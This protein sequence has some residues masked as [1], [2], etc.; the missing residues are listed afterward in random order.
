[1][2]FISRS[3][4]QGREREAATKAKEE[5][6]SVTPREVRDPQFLNACFMSLIKAEYKNE[7]P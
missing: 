3:G 6:D 2:G 5:L 4:N 7:C 1:M